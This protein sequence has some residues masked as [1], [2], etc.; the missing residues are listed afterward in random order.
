MF[1]QQKKRISK[2]RKR[3]Q[4]LELPARQNDSG[5]KGNDPTNAFWLGHCPHMCSY[6]QNM[7]FKF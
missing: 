7:V 4:L 2:G 5:F 3:S 6:S 1:V